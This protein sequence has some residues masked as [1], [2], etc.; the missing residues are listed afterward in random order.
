M[1]YLKLLALSFVLLSFNTP[2][3][4]YSTE[5]AVLEALPSAEVWGDVVQYARDNL[6][7]EGKLVIKSDGFG[8]IK[9]DDA[10]IH[11]LFPLLGVSEDG[12]KEP[13]YF[14][15]EDSPGAHI[16]LFYVDE[17]VNPEEAGQT[18]PFEL[19]DIVVVNPSKYNSYIVFEVKSPALEDLREKYGLERKLHG[20]EFHISL[21]KKVLQVKKPWPPKQ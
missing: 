10:Y 8:Y 9:V 20:H 4:S 16:S 14:R 18:F 6:P 3:F 1:S 7:Q 13:P 2:S 5:S 12:F 15:S 17:E 19:V 11:E 21:A